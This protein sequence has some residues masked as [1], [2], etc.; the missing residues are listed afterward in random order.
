MGTTAQKLT[1][2]NDTK[3]LLKDS[4]NSLGGNITSQTTFRQYATE[5]DSIYSN[6]PKVS[7]TGSILS[8][9][10]TL[11]GRLG[12][13]LKGNTFQQT[14][15]G[16]N[17]LKNTSTNSGD[18]N[19]WT[20]YSTFDEAAGEL[21]RNT[22]TTSE[23]FIT[24]V[25]NGLKSNTTYTLSFLAKSNGYVNSMDTFCYNSSAQGVK[26]KNHGRPTTTF[27]K[28]IFTF[29]T[30]SDVIYG[31][32][33]VIRFD[34]NGSTQSGTE[35][36]L[37]IKDVML[38][39]GEDTDFEP[40]VGGTASPNPDYPQ[41]IQS[42][43]GL[44]NIKLYGEQLYNVNDIDIISGLTV[45]SE[46]WITGT[47]NNTSGSSTKYLNCFTPISNLLK[48]NT[49]YKVI[50]EIKSRTGNFRSMVIT[51]NGSSSQANTNNEISQ[52]IIQNNSVVVR[53]FI[54]KSDFT[55]CTTMLRTYIPFD[56]GQSGS[57]TFRISVVENMSITPE[58]FVYEPYQTPQEYDI[59]LGNIKLNKIGDY[60]DYI[61]GTP[62]NWS[63]KRQIGSVVLDGSENL[64]NWT[65]GTNTI[66]FKLTNVS[67][68]KNIESSS[69][70][71]IVISNYFTKALTQ[72]ALTGNDV[73]GFATTNSNFYFKI[74]KTT[75]NSLAN[76][77]TWLS[78][79]NTEVDYV[80]ATETTEAITN[81][82]I[83]NQ[84][85][86][87]YYLQSYNGT[88]NITITSE[89]LELIMTASAIKGEA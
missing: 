47:V 31:T 83:I 78:T 66:G 8:L 14:Y 75:A 40:Y 51:N 33:T 5:L 34:N 86:E 4:I 55:N 65:S 42:V 25:L 52:S 6:L 38:V 67:N 23:T 80:L 17:L 26:T 82:E 1:Y 29:T 63:I 12:S 21:T 22:T 35:A 77:K 56:A 18:N 27:Q 68:L 43:T 37:T 7:G 72:N 71:N 49:T 53:N 32:G 39:E 85:N 36:I 84:L 81:Q 50:V 3:G 79:H 60:Q 59:N 10:P 28:Y 45:D 15:T 88:T 54:T 69:S 2:L 57:I 19:Y 44:Q 11:K 30:A 24:H 41:T 70:E 89:D 61:T 64:E 62:D 76:F 87:I 16:K 48:T 46:G 73:E 9:T 20:S 74:N 58:T 13:V